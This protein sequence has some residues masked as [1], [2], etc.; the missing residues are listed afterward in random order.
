MLYT[1]NLIQ[2]IQD[3]GLCPHL[4]AN[5]TQING[6]CRPSASLELQKV[7]TNCLNDVAKWMRSNRFQLN[8]AKTEILWSSISR[9]LHLLP[10]SPLRVGTD[11]VMPASVVRDL[12]I[13]ID[14]DVTLRS[15][16]AKTICACFAALR[17][18]RS[19]C[20]F[21][22]RPVLQSLVSSL[23]LMQMDYG[24]GSLIGISLYQLK[25]LQ[26][27]INSSAQLVF[28]S[29]R[30]DHITL[31]LRQLHWLKATQWTDYELA[32]L[33]YK[34]LKG[35][36]PSCLADDLCQKADVEARCRLRLASS[37]CLVVR[38]MRL[39]TYGDQAFP[40]A[41]S[42]VWNSLPYHVTSA[43]TASFL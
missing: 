33:V 19:V 39:S 36:V 8:T 16:V 1:A 5:N 26:S 28:S 6:F 17:Q 40:V 27:V 2:L 21:V 23:I 25:R 32:F 35:V 20:R 11:K 37:P 29:S 38:R 12:G 42:R 34:C 10:K 9:R 43:V 41:T 18:L 4:Y 22:P 3:H 13:Y 30:Y 24:N 15:H 7:I 31:L 14:S